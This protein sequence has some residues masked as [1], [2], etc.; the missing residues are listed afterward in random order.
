MQE[1]RKQSLQ[2]LQSVDSD[3]WLKLKKDWGTDRSL[4]LETVS[5]EGH[6]NQ[7]NIDLHVC[8]GRGWRAKLLH[9]ASATGMTQLARDM[10]LLEERS[11][12][13]RNMYGQTP[14]IVAFQSGSLEIVLFLLKRGADIEAR[15]AHGFTALHWLVSFSD[16]EKTKLASHLPRPIEGVNFFGQIPIPISSENPSPNLQG[17]PVVTGTPLHWAV[18]YLDTI[19]VN[20][21]LDLGADASRQQR[22]ETRS[23]F[24]QACSAHAAGIIDRLLKETSIKTSITQYQNFG[25][26]LYVNP[27]FWVLAGSSRFVCLLKH[28]FSFQQEVERVMGHLVGVGVAVDAVL[29]KDSASPKMS[30]PFATA[31]HRCPVE[32][33]RA[34]L[35]NGFRS[36]LDT[37]FGMATSGGPAMSLAI[38]HNDRELFSTLLEAGASVEWRNVYKQSAL[39]MV[40]KETDDVWFATRLLEKGVPVDDAEDPMSAFFFATYSGNLNVARFLWTKG[41]RRDSRDPR[42]KTILGSLIQMRTRNAANCVRF[43]LGLPDRNESDGFIVFHAT[44]GTG[45]KASAFHIALVSSESSEV[46]S[47]DPDTI[48]TSRF[49]VSLLLQKYAATAYINS[50][51]GAHYGVP[52]GA[53]VE[54]GNHHVVRLLLEAGANPNAEDEYSRRPLDLLYWRY[55]YPATL[56][57]IKEVSPDDKPELTK[58][59][60]NVNQHTSEILS[61]LKSYGAEPNIFRFPAWHQSHP[62]Y[63]NVEWV[64]ARLNERRDS[65]SLDDSEKPSWG[66]LPISIPERPMQF[67]RLRILAKQEK[68]NKESRQDQA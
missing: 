20:I 66:G 23:P 36:Y 22:T 37:T 4:Q 63:R 34:G 38:A 40:A 25:G 47:E 46:L 58:R 5:V 3:A 64:I 48:E 35:K 55:C 53:A 10:V 6:E 45:H 32:L 30:A 8:E 13:S 2:V 49:I 68:K 54:I 62:G 43:I 17:G 12:E 7:S 29:Q 18:A 50:T 21:L 19:A 51:A 9:F 31:Y 33:M 67:E 61:L 26:G 24:E 27:M 1:N 39:S 15:D 28:G 52:L 42:G 16:S 65:P 11:I 57:Y 59:L 56:D 44:D 41:A 14:L 60:S